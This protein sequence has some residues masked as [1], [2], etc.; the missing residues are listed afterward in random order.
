MEN[1]KQINVAQICE[2]S[3]FAK[4]ENLWYDFVK[5]NF[6][7]GITKAGF[8]Q[9]FSHSVYTKEELEEMDNTLYVEDYKVYQKPHV[10]IYMSNESELVK[11]FETV[12]ELEAFM[13]QEELKTV[14]WIKV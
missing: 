8:T 5:K 9:Q 7:R 13:G 14:K 3:S 11:F 4:E 1:L 6:W 10:V 12:E 2:I